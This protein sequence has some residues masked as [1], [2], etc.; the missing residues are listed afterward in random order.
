MV[1]PDIPKIRNFFRL[2]KL[3]LS[4]PLSLPRKIDNFCQCVKFDHK[5]R[6]IKLKK[7]IFSRN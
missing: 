3:L 7:N 5:K 4:V 6:S 1:L 2:S